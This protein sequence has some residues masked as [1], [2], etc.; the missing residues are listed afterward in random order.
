[1]RLETGEG[2]EAA[3][4]PHFGALLRRYRLDVG[5]TQQDLAERAN[6]SVEAIGTLERGARTRPHR[7]TVA[8]IARALALSPERAAQLES[9][10]G[11]A[12]PARPRERAEPVNASLLRIVHSD[13]QSPPRPNLPEQLTSFVGREREV[14][15]VVELVREH[16]LV[17]IV[18]SGGIGKT[19]VAAQVGRDVL[20][21]CS[22]GVWLVDLATLTDHTLV[23][24][25]ILTALQRP[26]TTGSSLDAVV[27]YLKERELLL[28]L[29]NCEHVLARTRDVAATI[30]QACPHVRILSTSRA[31]LLV[32]GERAFQLRSL[33][34][35]PPSPASGGEAAAYGAVALFLDRARAV[36]VGFA[37]TDE[38]APDVAEICRRLDGIP[39][40]LELAAAR[41]GML[42]P[43]QIAQRL[44]QRFRLL[45]G[46]DPRALPRHQTMT[47]S[48]DWSYDLL[49]P[50]EQLFF[51]TLSVFAGGCTLEAA[52]AVCAIE[53]EDDVDAIDLL[54]SLVTKSL[55]LAELVGYERRYRLLESSRQYA[56]DKLSARGEQ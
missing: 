7:D 42:A 13:P 20:G 56:A 9:A 47:A 28:I 21:G 29:D 48:L 24:G 10:V 55:V 39:L 8:L 36:D 3:A 25:A 5:M 41:V 34:V 30:V 40:A 22:D 54:A 44:D 18:G 32:A 52:T 23:A 45:T 6:L 49:S 31:A 37:L 1:M 27:G 11:V 33:T 51:E 14:G 53:T 46:G 19:R 4:R 26:A 2:M 17:T 15:E 12:H 38:N 50:R 35:P 16:R 43:R